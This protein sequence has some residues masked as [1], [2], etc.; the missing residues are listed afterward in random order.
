MLRDQ[1]LTDDPKYL[2]PDLTDRVNTPVPGLIECLVSGWINGVVLGS[3]QNQMR[4]KH[5]EM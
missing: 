2:R 4:Q 1:T 5:V 3:G